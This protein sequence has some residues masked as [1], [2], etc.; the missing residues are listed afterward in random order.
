MVPST[1][2]TYENSFHSLTINVLSLSSGETQEHVTE[3]G[4]GS[5]S[6]GYAKAGT[7]SPGTSDTIRDFCVSAPIKRFTEVRKESESHPPKK[8]K[9]SRTLETNREESKRQKKK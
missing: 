7:L 4:S 8:A 3:G 5:Q 6:V 1:L 2:Q 9:Y